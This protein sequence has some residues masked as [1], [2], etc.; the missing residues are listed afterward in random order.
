MRRDFCIHLQPKQGR[1]TRSTSWRIQQTSPR[2][3]FSYSFFLFLR[4]SSSF[5]QRSFDRLS[6]FHQSSNSFYFGLMLLLLLHLPR[7]FEIFLSSTTWL[8]RRQWWTF[9]RGL[10]LYHRLGDGGRGRRPRRIRGR[11]EEEEE[12]DIGGLASGEREEFKPGCVRE[13][14]VRRTNDSPAS[15]E[16]EWCFI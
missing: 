3:S 10:L 11:W 4:L 12:Y 9:M 8:S 7:G 13:V 2:D 1:G 5:C 6:F 14:H 16:C 15:P